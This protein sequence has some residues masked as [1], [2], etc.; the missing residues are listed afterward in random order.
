VLH[1][2]FLVAFPAFS[3]ITIALA[4]LVIYGLIVRGDSGS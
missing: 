1:I 2:A 3:L 4:V